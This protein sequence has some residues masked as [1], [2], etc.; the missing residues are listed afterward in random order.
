MKS[1]LKVAVIHSQF[2]TVGGAEI[3]CLAIVSALNHAGIIPDLFSPEMPDQKLYP[4]MSKFN[5]H[6]TKRFLEGGKMALY[7]YLVNKLRLRI[8]SGYDIIVD[9]SSDTIP[10]R[11]SKTK[12]VCYV[13]NPASFISDFSR[14]GIFWQL[15]RLPFIEIRKLMLVHDRELSLI[16]NSR[17]TAL[18]IKECFQL[19]SKAIY[20]PVKVNK[21]EGIISNA[22]EGSISVGRFSRTKRYEL[23]VSLAKSFPNMKFIIA[24]STTTPDQLHYFNHVLSLARSAS[25]VYLITNP[26]RSE[27]E[28]LF[29]KSK[30]FIHAMVNEDFGI[31]TIEAI[32]LGCIPFVHNSG[33]QKEIVPFNQ[34]RFNDNEIIEKFEKLIESNFESE[35][36]SLEGS[37]KSYSYERFSDE[38]IKALLY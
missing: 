31:A 32:A 27:L 3:V 20:P 14:K 13:H 30:Y 25:N 9:T 1:Q 2:K 22:R 16:A 33:G 5:F 37:V 36:K 8:P 7:R 4:D 23:I 17:F 18:R 12:Y 10:S 26:D 11:H 24:G 6:Q 38:I 21:R 19:N 29:S 15:Y 35:R 28:A 34:L